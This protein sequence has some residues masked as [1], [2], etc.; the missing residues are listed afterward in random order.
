M[1]HRQNGLAKVQIYFIV[2]HVSEMIEADVIWQRRPFTF[3]LF[4]PFLSSMYVKSPLRK[5]A[6][7]LKVLWQVNIVHVPFIL[8]PCFGVWA[9]NHTV[10]DAYICLIVGHYFQDIALQVNFPTLQGITRHYSFC[11][12]IEDTAHFRQKS[13]PGKLFND[14]KLI[15][16]NRF[17]ENN[18]SDLFQRRYPR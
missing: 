3:P 4:L 8:L 10:I 12:S 15:F 9:K 6:V 2:V 13:R 7:D 1:V 16:I 5:Y 18:L 14:R 11:Y 17:Y